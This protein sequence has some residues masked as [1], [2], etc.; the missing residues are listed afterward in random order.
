M[1]QNMGL[2]SSNFKNL[3]SSH[4]IPCLHLSS[5]PSDSWRSSSYTLLSLLVSVFVL[6]QVHNIMGMSGFKKRIKDEISPQKFHI[7]FSCIFLSSRTTQIISGRNTVFV[8]PSS[9]ILSQV[10]PQPSPRVIDDV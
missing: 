6:L 2:I 3:S 10:F 5:L 7:F 4:P 8:S 1:V 9:N